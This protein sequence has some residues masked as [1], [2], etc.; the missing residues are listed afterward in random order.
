MVRGEMERGGMRR[1]QRPGWALHRGVVPCTGWQMAPEAPGHGGQ[2]H[3]QV[4]SQLKGVRGGL[5]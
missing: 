4:K 5:L 2:S 1:P 3:G